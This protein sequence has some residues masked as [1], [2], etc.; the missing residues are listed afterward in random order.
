MD[1]LFRNQIA[2]GKLGG[3]VEPAAYG[4]FVLDD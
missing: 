2:A 4:E 1:G 3:G